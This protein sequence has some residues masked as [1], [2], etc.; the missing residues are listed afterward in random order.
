MRP[1]GTITSRSPGSHRIRISLGRDRDGKRRFSTKTV[2]GTLSEA[3][4]ELTRLLSAADVGEHVDPSRVTVGE[5]LDTWIA[6]TKA[7]VSGKTHE[8]YAEIVRCYLRPALGA[9]PRAVGVR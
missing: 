1:R 2:R 4:R 5:W 6:A 3:K 7:E 8:R 9:I